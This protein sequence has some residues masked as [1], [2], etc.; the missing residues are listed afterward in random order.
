[1]LLP[2][3]ESAFWIL[4][5]AGGLLI[6]QCDRAIA[7]DCTSRC[8]YCIDAPRSDAER[9]LEVRYIREMH[10]YRYDPKTGRYAFVLAGQPG[11]PRPA[12]TKA[13]N[14]LVAHDRHCIPYPSCSDPSRLPGARCS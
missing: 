10:G 3:I 12:G 4:V 13:F 8:M 7:E 11:D 9:A 6:A 2:Q 14:A 1:M 5:I